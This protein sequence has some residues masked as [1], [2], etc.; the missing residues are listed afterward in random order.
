M[1]LTHEN[2]Q[3]GRMVNSVIGPKY[4]RINGDI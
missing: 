3:A 4:I 1:I 2:Y